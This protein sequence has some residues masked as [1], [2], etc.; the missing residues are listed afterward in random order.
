MT[1]PKEW[2][3]FMGVPILVNPLFSSP[4]CV[5]GCISVGQFPCSWTASPHLNLL[6][7][8]LVA[9]GTFCLGRQTGSVHQGQL[10]AKGEEKFVDKG[11]ASN[12]FRTIL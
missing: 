6:W 12:S 2:G 9:S 8:F 10:L 3:G 5:F 4:T 7:T 11:P 1:F